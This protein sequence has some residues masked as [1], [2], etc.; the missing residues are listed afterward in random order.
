MTESTIKHIFIIVA[1]RDNEVNAS[2]RLKIC[3]DKLEE[4]KTVL[5]YINLSNLNFNSIAKL[6]VDSLHT[7]KESIISLAELIFQKTLGN[8]IF[9]IEFL[10]SVYSEKLLI[11]E[12]TNNQWKW[13]EE[14]INK[15][16][17]EENV[18]N[19]LSKRMKKLNQTSINLLKLASCLGSKLDLLFLSIICMN[20]PKYTW[21]DA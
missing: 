12:P 8:A 11:Y 6:I 3:I 13:D 19:I 14:T 17:V 5:Q 20:E 10:K 21:Y 2:H 16:M 9:S 7:D 18:A 15:R 4:K 1:F